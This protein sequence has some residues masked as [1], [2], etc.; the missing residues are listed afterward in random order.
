MINDLNQVVQ[1]LFST[2]DSLVTVIMVN[3]I[4]TIGFAV[5]VVKKISR[6]LDHIR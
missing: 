1:F 2:M 6:L 4:L 5:W 3:G